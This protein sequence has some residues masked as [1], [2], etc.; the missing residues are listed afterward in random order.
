LEHVASSKNNKKVGL[1]KK[2]EDKIEKKRERNEL[3]LLTGKIQII[4]NG[5]VG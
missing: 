2:E 5:I 4:E 3:L 1:D